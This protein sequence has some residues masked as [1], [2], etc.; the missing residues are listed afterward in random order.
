MQPSK[1]DANSTAMD[2]PQQKASE[3]LIFERWRSSKR[4]HSTTGRIKF[5]SHLDAS[6]AGV[7][8]ATL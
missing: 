6:T 8:N 2:M 1:A 7:E 4:R 5:D 3:K